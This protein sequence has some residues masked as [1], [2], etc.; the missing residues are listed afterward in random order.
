[1][2]GVK[3]ETVA[4]RGGRGSYLAGALT[5]WDW[6][7]RRRT[8]KIMSGEQGGLAAS[9]SLAPSTKTTHTH[10]HTCAGPPLRMAPPGLRTGSHTRLASSFRV[11]TVLTGAERCGVARL[12]RCS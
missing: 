5:W 11:L 6:L 2:V 1:M 4:R 3:P 10:T 8:L 12:S 9:C 7:M